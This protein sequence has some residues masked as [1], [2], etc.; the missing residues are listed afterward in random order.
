MP[1]KSELSWK[2][3]ATSNDAAREEEAAPAL[4]QAGPSIRVLKTHSVREGIS[5]VEA[6]WIDGDA[7][8]DLMRGDDLSGPAGVG[9]SWVVPAY[10]ANAG[11]M[12]PF[13]ARFAPVFELKDA[14]PN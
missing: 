11:D 9:G 5:E 10:K 13:T 2:K 8:V 7:P 6:N 12:A 1:P 14:G 4:V 3:D